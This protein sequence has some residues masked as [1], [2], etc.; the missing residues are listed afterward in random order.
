MDIYERLIIDHG[1]QRGMLGGVADTTGA[2]DQ[3]KRLFNAL[4]VELEAHANAEEQVFYAE[5]IAE[6]DGQEKARHSIV[7]HHDMNDLI[8]EL[9]DMDM[10]DGAWLKK[11]GELSHKVEHHL[12]E[13]EEEIFVRA[14]KLIPASRAAELVSAFDERKTAEMK[15]V[16]N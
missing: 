9:E 13:E 1:K 8:A 7:E 3:R 16:A 15:S 10:S 14:K 4:K 11:F 2:S 5:L 12:D 6:P